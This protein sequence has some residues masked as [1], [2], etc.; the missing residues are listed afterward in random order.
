MRKYEDLTGKRF[1]RMVVLS[2]GE[3][4]ISPKGIK[5]RKWI[6]QCDCGKTKAVLESSLLS[7][8]TKSCGCLWKD[9]SQKGLRRSLD[10][11]G[12]KIRIENKYAFIKLANSDEEMICD[13]EDLYKIE[14]FRW[15]LSH[16]GY[17]RCVITINGKRRTVFAHRFL[18][19]AKK[20]EIVD[21]INR[22]RLDNRRENLR[23]VDI[24]ASSINRCLK[25]GN[26]TGYAGVYK[27]NDCWTAKITKDG[28]WVTIGRFNTF[29]EA[30]D[31]RR[32]AEKEIYGI[33]SK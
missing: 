32:K 24:K 3:D 29:D 16:K 33:T 21:H 15:R 30:V 11:L 12:N 13:K 2:Q 10:T 31:A 27:N 9:K 6:C 19:G 22:N 23:I 1:G 8:N 25:K 7:G 14:N 17:A 20:E 5:R 26:K 18:I 28:K 4:Y